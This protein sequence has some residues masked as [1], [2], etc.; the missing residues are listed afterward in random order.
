[1]NLHWFLIYLDEYFIFLNNMYHRIYCIQIYI[2]EST[3]FLLFLKMV[4]RNLCMLIFYSMDISGDGTNN[5]QFL[6]NILKIDI[7]FS[8]E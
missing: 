3:K 7:C 4:F 1:M 8:I 5:K 6:S 2:A